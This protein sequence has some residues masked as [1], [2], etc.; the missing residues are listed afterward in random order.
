MGNVQKTISDMK[1]ALWVSGKSIPD[2]R[3][4][5]YRLWGEN[6]LTG[7]VGGARKVGG[8]GASRPP[9]LCSSNHVGQESPG[10]SAESQACC[11]C[12]RGNTQ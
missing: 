1:Y 5:E 10:L 8:R 9:Q 12:C 3:K 6:K 7:A 2:R 11:D 4:S